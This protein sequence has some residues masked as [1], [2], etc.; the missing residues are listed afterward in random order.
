M[1]GVCLFGGHHAGYPR[2]AVILS[3]L[4]RLGVPVA[5]CVA[6]PRAKV[7]RR[8]T[9]LLRRW[10]RLDR[11]SFEA[12]YVPEFRHKDMPLAHLLARR[13]GIPCVFDPLV[14]RFDTRVHDRGDADARGLQAAHN[15]NLDRM[16]FALADL[17][18]ADTR[19]HANLY[20]TELAPPD[21]RVRVLEVGY[22][23]AVFQPAPP[24]RNQDVATILFYGSFL[25]L[26]GV[27]VV[28]RAAARLRDDARI[29]F[30]LVGGG[31][32]RA[33]VERIVRDHRLANVSLT[34]RIP[35][36]ELP[37][38]IASATVCLGIFGTTP[39]AMRVIP[40]KVS[41]CMGME[42]AVITMDSPALRDTFRGDEEI[43]AIPPG[44]AEALARAVQDLVANTE[45]RA[46]IAR[47][48]AAR[49]ARDFT[50]VPL[51]RRFLAYCEEARAA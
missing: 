29:R 31:Q 14:S 19:A 20:M 13:A 32:T 28:A 40:N 42:R 3:G 8:Y 12:L 46:S 50:P 15:K 26:H 9:E 49:V 47:A 37:A 10:R 16:S 30:E 35:L 24:A 51:A 11:R 21:T 48:G 45:R 7:L 33:E 25:P 23:D 6:N 41:Q 34:A 18:L 36:A 22:D 17:V 43:V 5:S 38:R 2:S 4:A 39:K 44:D 27:E 1:N